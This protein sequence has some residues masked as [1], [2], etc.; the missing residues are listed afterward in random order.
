MLWLAR[1]Q[2]TAALL[3]ALSVGVPLAGSAVVLSLR[4]FYY[5]RFII[6]AAVAVWTLVALGAEVALIDRPG[7]DVQQLARDAVARGEPKHCR[8]PQS[9]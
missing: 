7:T 9:A 3:L 1:R 2:P 4:P 8:V 5:P 6:F